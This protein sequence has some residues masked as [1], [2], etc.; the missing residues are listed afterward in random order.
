MTGIYLIFSKKEDFKNY[1]GSS[2]NIE[3]RINRHK[4]DIKRLSHNNKKLQNYFI[5]HGL[6]NFDFKILKSCEVSELIKQEQYFLDLLKPYF[7]V[8]KTAYSLLGYKHSDNSKYIIS[9]KNTGRKMTSEQVQKGVLSRVG[10][11][12]SKGCKRTP[13][14][15]ANLSAKRKK[16]VVYNDIIFDSLIELSAEIGVK[17]QT[18][19]AMLSNRNTNRLNVTYYGS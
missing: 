16:K 18:L 13:E 12:T 6:E 7:N 9:F 1:V 3:N 17:Y 4:R 8:C 15:K 11:K 14:T 10:Q 19:Y 5:K 2:V